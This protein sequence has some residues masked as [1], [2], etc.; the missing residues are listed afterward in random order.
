[1]P[2]VIEHTAVKISSK[3]LK[4]RMVMFNEHCYEFEYCL[5]YDCMGGERWCDDKTKLREEYL[6]HFEKFKN[7]IISGALAEKYVCN[8]EMER[9]REENELLRQE[10]NDHKKVTLL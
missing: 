9:L 10:L 4:M 8:P 5:D 3:V 1:M 7:E 2:K 6:E